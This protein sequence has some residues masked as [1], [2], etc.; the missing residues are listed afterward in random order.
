MKTHISTHMVQGGDGGQQNRDKVNWPHLP[1]YPK[2]TYKL[3][4]LIR[5]HEDKTILIEKLEILKDGE[6]V[7]GISV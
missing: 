7:I 3:A 4:F 5:T 2:E 1:F 6:G